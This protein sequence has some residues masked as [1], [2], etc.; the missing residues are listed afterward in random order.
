MRPSRVSWA[1]PSASGEPMR[2]SK[3]GSDNREGRKF[4]AGCGAPLI[5]SCPKCG[6]PNQP[7]ERFCGECGAALTPTEP[8]NAQ[9][10]P[11]L[12]GGPSI[13]VTSGPP[14]DLAKAPDLGGERKT[15]TALFA[16][17]KGSMELM[18]DIDPEDARALVDPA[19]KLMMDAVRHY[20]G[21]I[22]QSTGDGIFALFGAPIAHEDHPQRALYAA[23]R[24]QEEMRRYAARLREVGNLPIEARVGVNTGEVVV[25]SLATGEGHA[26]YTP[27][28]HSTSLAARMQVLAPTGS[29]AAADATR[30][31]CEGYFTFKGLGPTRVKGVTGAV[32]VYEVTGLGPLRTHFQVSIRRGLTKFIGRQH[33]L[34]QMKRALELA[35]AG[36]GGVVAAAGDPGLGKSRLFYE[37]KLAAGFD[38]KVLEAYSVSYGKVSGYL[39]VIELL[40]DYFE[41]GPDDDERKRREK[42]SGKI[43][44]LD[45]S[46][47]DTL[48]YLF[49]LLGV[50]AGDDPLAQLDPQIKRRRA[51]EAIKRILM[52]ESLN[53]PLIVIFEDL[54]WIDSET[55]ELLNLLVENLA[56]ARILL[57]VNYRPEYR[58]DWGNRNYYTQLRLE[59]LGRES[60]NEM[61][62]ALLGDEIELQPLRRLIA[63]KTEG[64]PF[65]I[66]EMFQAL[67]EEGALQRNGVLQLT[68][69][70]TQVRV[71][72]TVQAV[73]TSRIDRLPT[74]EKDL[75]HTLAVLGREFPLSLVQRLV[76][77]SA[78]EL[79]R[80]LSR[81]QIGDFIYEQPAFPEV[82]Y[83]FKHALTQE[84]TYNSLLNERR[85]ALHE[86]AATAIEALFDANLTDHYSALAHHYARSGNRSKAVKYL[87]LAGRQAMDRSAY[88]EATAQLTVALELL[89]AQP[90]EPER[91]RTEVAVRLSLANCMRFSASFGT[92]GIAIAEILEP[93]RELS[94]KLDNDANLFAVLSLLAFVYTNRFELPKARA[95][96]NDV[97]RIAL[98]NG[99]PE[100]VGRAWL[101]LGISTMWEGNFTSAMGELD[102][103][104]KMS[105]AASSK[106]EREVQV[107][108][109]RFRNRYIAAWTSWAL[110][111]PERAAA[112]SRE[113]FALVRNAYPADLAVALHW[114][115]LYNLML[116][117]PKTAYSHVVEAIRLAGEH[118]LISL[119]NLSEFL[120]GWALAQLGQIEEGLSRMLRI[121]TELLQNR[122]VLPPNCF[123]ALAGTYLTAG[124]R[125]EGLDTAN[126]ALQFIQ[127]SGAGALEA[128]TLRLKG[129][130][131]SLG[132]DG[133][134]AEAAQ[135]FS[136]AIQVA[137]RQGAKSFEL[138]ATMSLARLPSGQ[139]PRDEAR[140]MLAEIY[141]WFTEGFDT[142][143]LKEAKALLDELS[144]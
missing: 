94:E 4:C 34:E 72:T 44:T 18:E 142:A 140:T 26:E 1:G 92:G 45:R 138:R 131:L 55:Q 89:Q 9:S 116:R 24:M 30:R 50:G 32:N 7:D 113:S 81:L 98:H 82:E 137:R 66:E 91:D 54:H 70:L 21:Y 37:F 53:Q 8:D 64:N 12:L 87:S 123:T 121:Q 40:K 96:G 103:G 97:L 108:D 56:K 88:T 10:S 110:G 136:A 67:I 42:V 33:E 90:D 19:L 60:A 48:D 109:W 20:G 135:C 102:E 85:Q 144:C 76:P 22:V 105:A 124:R 127:R 139:G 78:D 47:E 133:A 16:D 61:L 111:Y 11:T 128:E 104:Y 31:L 83:I 129:E 29:I 120:R 14:D 57:L 73:L 28:G 68:R 49:T 126:E 118:G 69:P 99:D 63:E 119:L 15:V 114:S 106:R 23:L 117:D 71:P 5:T 58:H 112:R 39:P 80:L 79:E 130:L 101:G 52:R 77:A 35:K 62:S 100:L 13:R 75:L 46:L 86:R 93:A 17:I 59:P 74:D 38:C 122:A 51:H 125:Q 141:N 84:V 134:A 25:R 95:L 143:D 3:C 41:I 27:I 43:I 65:F 132:N 6:A 36:H 115:A 107:W 2:C